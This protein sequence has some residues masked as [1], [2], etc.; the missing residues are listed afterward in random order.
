MARAGSA[1]GGVAEGGSGEGGGR[2]SSRT[3]GVGVVVG[4]G[5][6]GWAAVNAAAERREAKASAS[7]LRSQDEASRLA[8]VTPAE[9]FA[10]LGVQ[11]FAPPQVQEG[12]R[13]AEEGPGPGTSATDE[14]SRST[15]SGGEREGRGGWG[16]LAGYEAQKRE[17]EN[18]ILLA[19]AYPDVYR[20]IAAKTRVVPPGPGRVGP[21]AMLFE[22]PPGTG[23][24]TS[25]RAVASMARIP[26]VYV[27]LEAVGAKYYGDSEK[28]LSDVFELCKQL[29]GCLIFLDEVDS[30]AT[31][32]TAD[33]HEV[34]RRLLAVLLRQLDGFAEGG[35]SIVIAATNRKQDLDPAL[36]SRFDTTVTFGPPDHACRQAIFRQY[37]KQLPPAD[38]ATLAAATDGMSGRDIR[39]V[40]A[41]AERAFASRLVR[42]LAGSADTPSPKDYAA[43]IKD[44]RLSLKVP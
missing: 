18:D 26:L 4:V 42:G 1:G 41:K 35:H 3:V 5:V 31:T 28:L 27:P 36:L 10:A 34:T 15:D 14:P 11:Y 20:E 43:S 24:T 9:R 37:A 6:L 8:S 2:W 17:I 38:V 33:M 40:C 29:G 19:L 22:G 13:R 39:D 12:G 7:K 32:R 30:L 25:A 23:K 44:R 21:R 16:E